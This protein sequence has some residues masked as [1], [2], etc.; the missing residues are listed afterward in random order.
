MP[1]FTLV[2]T[3]GHPSVPSPT[4]QP[5]SAM[6]PTAPDFLMR[7]IDYR[8]HST[9]VIFDEGRDEDVEEEQ[10]S[11][12]PVKRNFLLLVHKLVSYKQKF[13]TGKTDPLSSPN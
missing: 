13:V 5:S 7:T 1:S 9:D 12:N 4:I 10:K 6:L 2:L 3:S 11:I 8:N